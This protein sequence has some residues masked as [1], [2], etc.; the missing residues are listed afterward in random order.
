[1]KENRIAGSPLESYMRRV[2]GRRA[3][4][5]EDINSASGGSS[6]GSGSGTLARHLS[7]AARVPPLI[8]NPACSGY[9][10]EPM[11][12]MEPALEA[13]ELAGKIVCPNAKCGAKLG[14][15][16]WA[17]VCCSCRQWVTP[18]FCIHRSKVDEVVV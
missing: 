10:V 6:N 8:T 18:G 14:N 16:D 12:W 1:M 4:G 2:H 9:F 17:G 11:K 7:A 13:G 5:A 3:R 15:Y